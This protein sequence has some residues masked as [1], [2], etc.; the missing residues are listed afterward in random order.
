MLVLC[1]EATEHSVAELEGLH[2]RRACTFDSRVRVSPRSQM[3]FRPEEVDRRSERVGRFTRLI[4]RLTEPDHD[5]LGTR[6]W[7]VW[8]RGKCERRAGVMARRV[9]LY[10]FSD[11]R[12][13]AERVRR[14]AG[15]PRAS[16][17]ETHTERSRNS[18][19]RV[20]D[21]YVARSNSNDVLIVEGDQGIVGRFSTGVARGRDDFVNRDRPAA[22]EESPQNQPNQRLLAGTPPSSLTLE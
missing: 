8:C 20:G 19:E 9:D 16:A 15:V 1:Q 11:H 14:A 10:G 17:R 5:A 22:L 18:G 21:V 6:P 12:G 2:D 13:H 7:S 3:F 4:A